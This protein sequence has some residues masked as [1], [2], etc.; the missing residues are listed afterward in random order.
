[1]TQSS[2]AAGPS[3]AA[4]TGA[5]TDAADGGAQSLGPTGFDRLLG[6]EI[7]EVSGDGVRG[8]LLVSRHVLQPY[9]IVH[10]GVYATLAET[11]ASIGAATWYLARTPGGQTVGVDNSTHFLRATREGA[12]ISVRATPIHRGRSLQLWQVEMTDDA[13]RLVARSE[14]RLANLSPDKPM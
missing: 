14:V 6:F 10:G 11:T 12:T 8:H 5:E 4:V 1:M 3:D 2:P 7:D 13:G 9:G